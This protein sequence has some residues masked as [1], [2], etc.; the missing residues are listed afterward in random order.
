MQW[1]WL[2]GVVGAGLF[3]TWVLLSVFAPARRRRAAREQDQGTVQLREEQLQV[4]KSR[5]QLAD[6]TTHKE[7]VREKKTVTVPV[8]RE[9]LVVEKDGEEAARIPLREERVEVSTRSVPLNEV[10]VYERE[11]QEEQEVEAVLK[12]EVARIETTGDATYTEE[13]PS[14]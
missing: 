2:W 1:L 9:E 11:W 8:T 5:V 14:H 3:L 13:T 10:S 4:R 6:V 7:V 12:K